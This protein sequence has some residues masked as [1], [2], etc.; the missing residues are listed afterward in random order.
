[1]AERQRFELW[2]G[3]KPTTV[4]KTA[5]LNHSAIS[6]RADYNNPSVFYCKSPPPFFL[7]ERSRCGRFSLSAGMPA[8]FYFSRI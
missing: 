6:P 8:V 5:A 3:Y 2:V 1:M 4:F 7:P